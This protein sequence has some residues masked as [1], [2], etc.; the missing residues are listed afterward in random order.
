L[1]ITNI[2]VFTILVIPDIIALSDI[3]TSKIGGSKK[4]KKCTQNIYFMAAMQQAMTAMGTQF[5]AQLDQVKK[6]AQQA[7]ITMLKNIEPEA[8]EVTGT[9]IAFS[10]IQK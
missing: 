2:I 4:F 6:E 10:G 1:F 8:V 7:R 9:I 3:S 5:A